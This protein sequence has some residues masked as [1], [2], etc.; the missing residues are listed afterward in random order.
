MPAEF[1]KPLYS[2]IEAVQSRIVFLGNALRN[3]DKAYRE[4]RLYQR[5]MRSD[6][7]VESALNIRILSFALADFDIEPDEDTPESLAEAAAIKAAIGQLRRLTQFKRNLGLAC[8]YGHAAANVQYK[9]LE[10]PVCGIDQKSGFTKYAAVVPSTWIPIHPDSVVWSEDGTYGVKLNM[11][12][13]IWKNLPDDRRMGSESGMAM[14][15]TPEQ[16]ACTIINVWGVEAPDF[17]SSADAAYRFAGRGLRTACWDYWFLKQSVLQAATLYAE[18]LGRPMIIGRFPSGNPQ[19]QADIQQCLANLLTDGAATMP[20]FDTG[21]AG[22]DIEV[23]EVQGTGY[24]VLESLTQRFSDGIT[25][26][27]L[28]QTLTTGTAPTGLGSGV[29]DEHGQVFQSI[30]KMDASTLD[31]TLTNDFVRV[32]AKLNFPESR[33]NYRFVTLTDKRNPKE[34]MESVEKFV[35]MGGRISEDA[36]REELGLPKPEDGEAP[37]GGGVAAMPGMESPGDEIPPDLQ[38]KLDE[39]GNRLRDGAENIQE[40]ERV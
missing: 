26:S 18:K 7:D 20:T 10:K 37:L 23:K 38:S 29:A 27:I 24:Q 33:Y 21:V 13:D 39:L 35:S 19:A 3:S 6:P 9:T 1:T 4:D 40:S 30:V 8:W 32:I 16:R 17:E 25:K 2:V 34:F 5:M 28:G 22:I 12:S 31:D 15:L 36:V 11:T 14:R